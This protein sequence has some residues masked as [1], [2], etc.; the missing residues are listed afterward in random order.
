MYAELVA[1]AK[2]VPDA[3]CVL[4]A[5]L[6]LSGEALANIELGLLLIKFVLEIKDNDAVL[7]TLDVL[8]VCELYEKSNVILVVRFR[9]AVCQNKLP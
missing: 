8:M 4:V 2:Y 6:V 3:E 7:K 9:A 5:K 1:V